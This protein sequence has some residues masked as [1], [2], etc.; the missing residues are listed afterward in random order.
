M[1]K[2]NARFGVTLRLML[3]GLIIGMVAAFVFRP[4][5]PLLGQ[6]PLAAV[7]TRGGSLEGL[8]QVWVPT[9]REAFDKML[10]WGALGALVGFGAAYFRKRASLPDA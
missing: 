5:V 10:L 2:K 8:D 7:L 9:A 4:A 3:I 6:P 1:M